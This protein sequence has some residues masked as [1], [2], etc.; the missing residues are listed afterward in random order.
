MD[1]EAKKAFALVEQQFRDVLSGYIGEPLTKERIQGVE[2]EIRKVVDSFSKDMR[3]DVFDV[4]I[5]G[6]T[7]RYTLQGPFSPWFEDGVV[8]VAGRIGDHE[9]LVCTY[10]Q[11][12]PGGH[13]HPDLVTSCLI[14]LTM[15][16]T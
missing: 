6:N 12:K 8:H 11:L 10:K 4:D 16:K 2:D 7:L 15:N 13:G 9:V 5:S 1:D 3:V 14:C